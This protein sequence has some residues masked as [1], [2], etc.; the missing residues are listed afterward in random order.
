M[1]LNYMTLVP[2]LCF[3]TST[4][5]QDQSLL[6]V[7]SLRPSGSLKSREAAD[8]IMHRVIDRARSLHTLMWH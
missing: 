1:Y 8:Y 7:E 4:K 6:T 3:E 5:P 2:M